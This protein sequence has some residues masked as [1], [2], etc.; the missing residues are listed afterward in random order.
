MYV[1]ELMDMHSCLYIDNYQHVI[2]VLKM[3]FVFTP[4]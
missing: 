3:A 4:M 2:Y 1:C